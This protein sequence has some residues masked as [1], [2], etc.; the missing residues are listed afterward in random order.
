VVGC[1]EIDGVLAIAG[2][3]GVNELAVGGVFEGCAVDE[4]EA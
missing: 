4:V 3:A 2:T 1:A